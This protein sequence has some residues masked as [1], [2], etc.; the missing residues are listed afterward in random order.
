MINIVTRQAE[1]LAP[2]CGQHRANVRAGAG[3]DHAWQGGGEWAYNDQDYD[4]FVHINQSNYAGQ[5]VRE[6]GWAADQKFLGY[7][8][9]VVADAGHR[10]KQAENLSV[11]SHLR[12]QQLSLDVLHVDQSRN[13]YNAYRDRSQF[14]QALTHAGLTHRWPINPQIDLTS[15]ADIAVDDYTLYA[16]DGGVITGGTREIRYG[17]QEILRINDLW[18]GNKLVLGAELRFY[19][20]GQNNRNGDNFILNV[21]SPENRANLA[22]L[23]QSHRYVYPKKLGVY[24][25]FLEDHYQ[26]TQKL[27]LFGGLRYDQH[28]FWGGNVSPRAGMF[29]A[30]WQDGL[31][32]LSYQEGF[33]GAV[34]MHYGGCCRYDGFLQEANFDQVEAAIPG[35]SNLSAIEPERIQSIELAFNQRVDA[36]WQ[37]DTVLFYSRVKNIIDVGGMVGSPEQPLPPI[38]TD[39]PGSNNNYWFFKN[40]TG[41][42]RQVGVETSGRYAT[43][44]FNATVSHAY[45]DIL[46]ASEQNL[47]SMYVGKT[48]ET[49]AVPQN[50]TRLNLVWKPL[51]KVS[52]GVNYLF[53]SDWFATTGQRTEGGHLLNTAL[54][55]S[56]S[57]RLEL[58]FNVKNLLGENNLYPM[59]NNVTGAVSNGAPA[60]EKTTFWLWA[61]WQVW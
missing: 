52:L 58:A 46:S 53:Y 61:K 30:P 57:R 47:G 24:S 56:P 31:F 25:V 3:L 55:Y 9:G 10:L 21:L 19:N 41:A 43:E 51:Q 16:H 27:T 1:Q 4:A 42:I 32:R 60:L 18:Q 40:N 12:Y 14:G 37:V 23:R 38:G 15:K 34:G 6:E 13:L 5:A 35:R 33:R 22:A 28:P 17:V 26:L 7:A 59:N 39:V 20:F 2:G 29:V 45:V 11:F 50:V 49:R 8:G 54:I 36:H 44:F 48:G